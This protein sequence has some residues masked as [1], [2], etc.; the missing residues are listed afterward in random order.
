MRIAGSWERKGKKGKVRGRTW[1]EEK[2]FQKKKIIPWAE[3][4][5]LNRLSVTLEF[6]DELE[7]K[8]GKT[9]MMSVKP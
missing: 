6:V 3:G 5:R 1:R 7:N 9:G 2:K 8:S 4:Y